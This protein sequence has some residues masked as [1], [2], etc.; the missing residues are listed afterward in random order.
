M[1][2]ISLPS[3]RTSLPTCL[4]SMYRPKTPN[5]TMTPARAFV[6]GLVA[7]LSLASLPSIARAET[8]LFGYEGRGDGSTADMIAAQAQPL[9]DYLSSEMPEHDFQLRVYVPTIAVSLP[10]RTVSLTVYLP[11]RVRPARSYFLLAPSLHP[12]S[13]RAT[14]TPGSTSRLLSSGRGTT[15]TCC[16]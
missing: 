10:R 15:A 6:V 13:I 1:S 14:L 12:P 4:L 7:L 9:M 3:Y 11:T 16:Q 5:E 8:F 2:Y